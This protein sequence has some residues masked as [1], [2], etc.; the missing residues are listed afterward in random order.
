MRSTS[1]AGGKFIFLL[2]EQGL[3]GDVLCCRRQIGGG[4]TRALRRGEA[5][6]VWLW[7]LHGARRRLKCCER[8]H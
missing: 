8:S 4:M 7:T 2:L 5:S 1:D 6:T 3:K